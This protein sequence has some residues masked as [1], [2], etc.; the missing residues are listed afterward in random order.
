MSQL[1]I[2]LAKTSVFV[3]ALMDQSPVEQSGLITENRFIDRIF[4]YEI[5]L[6]FYFIRNSYIEFSVMQFSAS[7]QVQGRC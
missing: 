3:K 2:E 5:K 7:E 4:E 1:L 6:V